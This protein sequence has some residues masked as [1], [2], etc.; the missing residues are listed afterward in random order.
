MIKYDE[1]RKGFF[2]FD[3][4]DEG[5][6]MI[7]APDELVMLSCPGGRVLGTMNSEVQ[8][9]CV[10]VNNFVEN[11]HHEERPFENFKCDSQP[12]STLRRTG[13]CHDGKSG[14]AIGFEVN[15]MFLKIIDI[16]FDET[17]NMAL[18]AKHTLSTRILG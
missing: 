10:G 13:E 16:C 18:Y 14:F 12:E 9:N 1:K 3:E 11:I 5:D 17:I 2:H 15:R 7:Y 4:P 8:L 6:S